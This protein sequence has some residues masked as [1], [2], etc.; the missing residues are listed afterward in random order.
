MGGASL[1]RVRVPDFTAGKFLRIALH[2]RDAACS[3]RSEGVCISLTM[4]SHTSA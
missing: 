1:V 3:M 2:R 4:R